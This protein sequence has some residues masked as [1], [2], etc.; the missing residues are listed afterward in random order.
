[1]DKIFLQ[2]KVKY[3]NEISTKVKFR[4]CEN[5][6]GQVLI[7][8]RPSLA[9]WRATDRVNSLPNYILHSILH[10]V[11]L[12]DT[13]RTRGVSHRF[14]KTRQDALA[15][16]SLL[17]FTDHTFVTGKVHALAPTVIT[18]ERC[19]NSN[20]MLQRCTTQCVTC[21]RGLL[22]LHRYLENWLNSA[23]LAT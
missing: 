8:Q 7:R 14:E 5:Q 22:Y 20:A 13:V 17:D 19:L 12:R 21:G 23:Q 1:M 3:C 11:P 2:L 16:S 10:G 18:V 15:T 4:D 6:N 9:L